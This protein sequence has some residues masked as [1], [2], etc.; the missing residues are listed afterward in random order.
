[1]S[2]VDG[3]YYAKLNLPRA[4]SD[5]QIHDAFRRLRLLYHPSKFVDPSKEKAATSIYRQVREAYEVLSSP[6]TRHIYD[7]RGTSGVTREMDIIK[8][9]ALPLEL[10]DKYEEV[11]KLW[12]ERTYIQEANPSSRLHVDIDVR[13]LIS[14]GHL[15]CLVTNIYGSQ[16]VDAL[17]GHSL[18]TTIGGSISAGRNSPGGSLTIS[19]L[20]GGEPQSWTGRLKI[21]RDPSV[22]IQYSKKLS[23]RTRLTASSDILFSSSSLVRLPPKC[24]VSLEHAFSKN[25]IGTFIAE[26]LDLSR[27]ES[28]IT[29]NINKTF[30]TIGSIEAGEDG[31]TARSQFGANLTEDC[32][33]KAGF[34]VATSGV[35]F[36]YGLQ[37][38][39]GKLTKLGSY[40]GLSG[41]GVHLKLVLHRTNQSYSARFHLSDELHIPVIVAASLFPVL[42]YMGI[43]LM[44]ILPIIRQQKEWEKAKRLKDLK[45]A[46]KEK[47]REAMSA[48]D[49]MQ[50]SADR[51]VRLEQVK[52]GLVITEAWYGKMSVSGNK[53]INASPNDEA[54][55]VSVPL[56]SM[57]DDSKLIIH[58]SDKSELVG[59]YDPAVG[60]SKWLYIKYDFRGFQHEVVVENS[61]K[62]AIPRESHRCETPTFD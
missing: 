45:A 28:S 38:S 19:L 59:F 62:V 37:Q 40:I 52:L 21:S 47:K 5:D 7:K 20:Q 6:V 25:I 32:V 51:I 60:H 33:F 9:T 12:E 24:S 23:A 8:R 16:S 17:I 30:F 14:Q 31:L 42:T 57:V 18:K 36:S 1:M 2:T 39:L 56:Q 13:T 49:L 55:D 53:R 4:A 41:Y 44:S 26:G 50:E 15:V 11:Y 48:V 29:Y 22:G 43:R 58:E 46:A 27:I 61:Q 10:V 35:S 34:K 3:D 54:I